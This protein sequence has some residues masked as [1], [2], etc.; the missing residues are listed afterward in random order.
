[1]IHIAVL[2]AFIIMIFPVNIVVAG[3]GVVG[4][5]TV[6][7][8]SASKI[9]MMF[10]NQEV[11]LSIYDSPA[12]RDF[13]ALLPLTM[14]FKDFARTEKIAYLPRKLDTADSPTPREAMGDFTYYAPWGN[15]A[16]FY[17]GFGTDGQ[18]FVLGRI[19]SGKEKLAVMG[20]TFTARLEKI[21]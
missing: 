15:L 2:F 16:V 7:I 5:D 13:L 1:M 17:K 12:S 21:E 19:E 4:D 6:P 8:Q 9:R 10:N 18:L 20:D 11:I 14:E 3:S